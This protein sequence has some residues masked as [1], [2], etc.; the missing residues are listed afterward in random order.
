MPE[1]KHT[2]PIL[3]R[4]GYRDIAMPV[5]IC[6]LSFL[7]KRVRAMN[8]VG[9]HEHDIGTRNNAYMIDLISNLSLV[10]YSGGNT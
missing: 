1:D 4:R 9:N 8:K 5:F 3:Y 2:D 6:F 7:T 10:G